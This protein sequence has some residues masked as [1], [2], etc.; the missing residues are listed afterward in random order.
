M[1]FVTVIAIIDSVSLATLWWKS[2]LVLFYILHNEWT[3]TVRIVYQDKECGFSNDI[4]IWLIK[5]YANIF[6][7]DGYFLKNH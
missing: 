4:L 3:Y 2:F 1:K 7:I 6:R 5:V